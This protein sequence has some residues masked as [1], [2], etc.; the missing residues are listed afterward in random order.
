MGMKFLTLGI[1]FISQNDFNNMYAVVFEHLH[2]L[3]NVIYFDKR[4]NSVGKGDDNSGDESI[5]DVF[6]GK[7]RLFLILSCN[8]R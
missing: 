8:H 3:L 5:V 4:N 1:T 7:S 6:V 2:Q